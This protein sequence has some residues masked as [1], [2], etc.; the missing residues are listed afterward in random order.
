MKMLILLFSFSAL[1]ANFKGNFKA[2]EVEDSKILYD[3]NVEY[4]ISFNNSSISFKPF[5]TGVKGIATGYSA[6]SLMASFFTVSDPQMLVYAQ[7]TELKTL[8]LAES[9]VGIGKKRLKLTSEW[10][11][12]DPEKVNET[13]KQIIVVDE[14]ELHFDEELI[15]L[16]L[17]LT[18]CVGQDRRLSSTVKHL[19]CQEI[20]DDEFI[21]GTVILDEIDFHRANS[22][23]NLV[24]FYDWR[25]KGTWLSGVR[26]P[27]PFVV[28]E[29]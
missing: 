28:V 26:G 13:L 23:R 22:N 19:G 15:K 5:L 8:T 2:Q 27:G 29:R 21:A 7:S 11:V 10:S 14:R 1:A 4:D 16:P 3:L 12:I 17:V 24:Y 6:E 25:V 9:S 20:Q 18:V